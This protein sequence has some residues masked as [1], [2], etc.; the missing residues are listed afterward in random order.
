MYLYYPRE[1]IFLKES[2]QYFQ[3]I[4]ETKA[5]LEE[6]ESVRIGNQKKKKRSKTAT[7]LVIVLIFGATFIQKTTSC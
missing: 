4:K 3:N 6:Q 7:D 2:L 5:K 1:L